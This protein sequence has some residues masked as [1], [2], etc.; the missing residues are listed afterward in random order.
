[1]LG[2]NHA[3]SEGDL[4]GLQLRA[5]LDE[6]RHGQAILPGSE[7]AEVVRQFFRQH[8]QHAIHEVDTVAAPAGF[9]ING[10]AGS[11]II[12]RVGNVNT[13]APTTVR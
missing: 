3:P 2:M 4:P 8:R 9:P 13:Q 7:T 10:A 1:M 11:H 12:T 5:E 6:T